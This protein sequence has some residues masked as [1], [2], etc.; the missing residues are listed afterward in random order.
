M[1]AGRMDRRIIIEV[2]TPTTDSHGDEID[3]WATL[4][5]VWAEQVPLRGVERQ[6]SQQTLA[7]AD[8]RFRIRYRTDVTPK[9]RIK[10]GSDIYDITAVMEIARSQGIEIMAK[11][12]VA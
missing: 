6:Q 9:N 10:I 4:D 11:L 12:N 7:Q 5:T 2:N 8:Y 1:R 3:S